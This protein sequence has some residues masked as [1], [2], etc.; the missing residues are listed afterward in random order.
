[1]KNNNLKKLPHLKPCALWQHDTPSGLTTIVV[2]VV[3]YITE[4]IIHLVHVHPFCE[5]EMYNT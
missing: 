5:K 4:L 3:D 2:L 1:M